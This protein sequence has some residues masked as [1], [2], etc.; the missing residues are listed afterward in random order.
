MEPK[1]LPPHFRILPMSLTKE[2][3]AIHAHSRIML[4]KGSFCDFQKQ[5]LAS[6]CLGCSYSKAGAEP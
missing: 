3:K 5:N 1:S 6:F 2:A 4:G